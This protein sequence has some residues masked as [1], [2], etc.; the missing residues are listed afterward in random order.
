MK[1]IKRKACHQD[2]A[3]RYV[4]NIDVAASELKVGLEKFEHDHPIAALKGSD[5][6]LAF[7]TK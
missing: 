5:N 4:G 3:V 6:T 7:H 2:K 1:R